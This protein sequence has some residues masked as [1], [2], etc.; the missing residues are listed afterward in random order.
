MA[1][2]N[3]REYK[4]HFTSCAGLYGM[5]K[6][7]T[8]DNPY[9]T[10][11]ATHSSFMNDSSEY[12]YGKEM[13]LQTLELYEKKHGIY[14]SDRSI[15]NIGREQLLTF[16]NEDAP[17]LISLSGNIKSAAMWSMY[18]TNGSGI[19]L[20]FDIATIQKYARSKQIP[21][22][23]ISC[24]YEKTSK[25]I[26]KKHGAYIA[27]LHKLIFAELHKNKTSDTP[28]SILR[29]LSAEI[30]HYSFS[31]EDEHRIAIRRRTEPILFRLKNNILVP[32]IEVKIPINA[33]WG[34]VVGPTADYEYIRKSLE[35]FLQN[36]TDNNR[37][38]KRIVKNISSSDIP[39]RG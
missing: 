5:L 17:Y 10:M 13:C 15:F 3:F 22:E 21:I 28:T 26:L 7:C 16:Q 37:A 35:I 2:E 9:L 25:D 4:Y 31:Y 8:K 18:S 30:K 32:Y 1:F 33:L 20:K 27:I 6:E 36:H 39:F 38:I 34:I 14:D 12:K 11:W 19:A 29:N 24:I 23:P